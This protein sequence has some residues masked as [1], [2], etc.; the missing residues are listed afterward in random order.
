VW[1]PEIGR[2]ILDT[3]DWSTINATVLGL[4]ALVYFSVH[5]GSIA[6]YQVCALLLAANRHQITISRFR[7]SRLRGG[8]FVALNPSIAHSKV[9]VRTDIRPQVL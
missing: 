6:R 1:Q 8:C 9:R 4:G 5:L 7:G 2:M 3:C